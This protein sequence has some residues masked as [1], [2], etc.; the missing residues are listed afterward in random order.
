MNATEPLPDQNLAD[1]VADRIRSAI[2]SGQY[3]PG[4]RLDRTYDMHRAWTGQDFG[5]ELP[6][7]VFKDR[8]I[9]CFIDDAFG[10]QSRQY[11]NVDNI[12][13]ECD[14]PH[15]DSTW[16]QAPEALMKYLEGVSDEDID[17]ITDRKSVV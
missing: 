2:W 15:S 3:Q 5:D 12:T 6:S 7:Q 16:P 10:V 9:T 17:K 8:V 4:D 1:A 11:M 13:W 14:Y